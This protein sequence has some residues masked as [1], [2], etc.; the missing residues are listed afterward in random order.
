MAVVIRSVD[1]TLRGDQTHKVNQTRFKSTNS[2]EIY[3]RFFIR[4]LCQEIQ[5]VK[6][7]SSYRVAGEVIPEQR[8]AVFSLREFEEIRREK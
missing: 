3:S 1:H 5:D 2:V 8:I 6:L 7:G 4:K